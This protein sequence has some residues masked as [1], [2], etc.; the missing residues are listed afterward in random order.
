MKIGEFD[1]CRSRLWRRLGY[2]KPR[3]ILGYSGLDAGP[4]WGTICISPANAEVTGAKTTLVLISRLFLT[5]G[6][7]VRGFSAV[8]SFKPSPAARARQ[9]RA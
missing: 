6:R 9:N 4:L 1:N 7:T 2:F 5:S 3:G 8:E